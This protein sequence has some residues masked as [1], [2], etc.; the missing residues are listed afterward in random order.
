MNFAQVARA[1]LSVK[2]EPAES[3]E[4]DSMVGLI[5]KGVEL[6]EKIN[7]SPGV[8]YPE[9]D[10]N[11]VDSEVG[12]DH[13]CFTQNPH[14]PLMESVVAQELFGMEISVP[15]TFFS[16][17][18]CTFTGKVAVM[19]T[20]HFDHYSQIKVK[21]GDS[22]QTIVVDIPALR[23]VVDVS[24]QVKM[25][26]SSLEGRMN[27]IARSVD[28]NLGTNEE[29]LVSTI[30]LLQDVTHCVF[31]KG[32]KFP[33]LPSYLGGYDKMIPFR[34]PENLERSI[35][36]FKRGKYRKLIY[37]ILTQFYAVLYQNNVPS[38]FLERIKSLYSG[39]QTWFCNYKR[40]FPLFSGKL[41]REM[42]QDQ[43]PPQV[44]HA[45]ISN[46]VVRRLQAE[47]LIV[48]EADLVIASEVQ[49]YFRSLLSEDLG[50]FRTAKL[51]IEQKFS[52][53][54][55]LSRTFQE[56]SQGGFDVLLECK[57]EPHI[58]EWAVDIRIS[59]SRL[60][61][62]AFVHDK[63]FWRTALDKIYL[64]SPLKVTFPLIGKRYRIVKDSDLKLDPVL[65]D[66]EIDS[67]VMTLVEWLRGDFK[68]FPFPPRELLED[69]DILVAKVA[70]I[71]D[72]FLEAGS[73]PIVLIITN[74][75]EMCKLI[76][77]STSVP[78]V[79]LPPDFVFTLK[80]GRFGY[81]RE[82][83]PIS[84]FVKKFNRRIP[85][86]TQS[87]SVIEHDT[88]VNPEQYPVVLADFGSWDA[89]SIKYDTA[90]YQRVVLHKEVRSDQIFEYRVLGDLDPIQRLRDGIEAWPLG[91]IFDNERLV[92]ITEF[93]HSE[94]WRKRED[95]PGWN[96][97]S[98]FN[99]SARR[100]VKSDP[101]LIHLLKQGMQES[102]F[103]A[104]EREREKLFKF[105]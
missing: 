101:N 85:G 19:P 62:N 18:Y 86:M 91:Y 103:L 75:S 13:V 59:D 24:P 83:E 105:D 1:Y 71:K 23:S 22:K 6:S 77:M 34:H 58:K 66:S 12:D 44:A 35:H 45:S 27:Y 28:Y 93:S 14:V 4:L 56:L 104:T 100:K 3:I 21:G 65:R 84:H 52:A 29:K 37:T 39:Y 43:I 51:E 92:K 20:D 88:V 10:I 32:N 30:S 11:Q 74:D 31:T 50:M 33:Y 99:R 60:F 53:E 41:P 40:N 63:Y 9:K 97:F 79:R 96:P 7:Y 72:K 54:T 47:G 38:Q 55:K 17:V 67:K 82:A 36:A 102:I 95:R 80:T 15:D 90:P 70:H 94:D 25:N 89:S 49:D 81:I 8:F 69:D 76:N 46:M 64:K 73:F 42:W 2:L 16:K 57:L 26:T 98:I 48:R 61:K 78:V 87:I 5:A 68:R